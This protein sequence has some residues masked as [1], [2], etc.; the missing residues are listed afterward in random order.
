MADGIISA[1]R[2]I[3]ATSRYM[4]LRNS[5]LRLYI[6]QKGKQNVP[7]FTVKLFSKIILSIYMC[8]KVLT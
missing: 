1:D 5:K 3:R 4:N 6:N 8:N 2:L 7:G